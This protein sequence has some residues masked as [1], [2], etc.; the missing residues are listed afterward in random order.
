ML[1]G[2][3]S[4]YVADKQVEIF[5]PPAKPRFGAVFLHAVGLES[6]GRQSH[7]HRRTREAKHRVCLSARPATAGGSIG[8]RPISMRR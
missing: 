5:D 6:S 7:L 3:S 8:F 1:A 2:W 4:S